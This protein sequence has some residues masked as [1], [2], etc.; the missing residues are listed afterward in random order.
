M[1]DYLIKTLDLKAGYDGTPVTGNIEL[2]IR[3]GEVLTLIGPNGSG[4]TTLLRTL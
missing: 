1:K 4:K 2:N 3:R